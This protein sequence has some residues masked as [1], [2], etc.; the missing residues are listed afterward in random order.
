VGLN[1]WLVLTCWPWL[2][3]PRPSG[4]SALAAGLALVALTFGAVS[5]RRR[6][7]TATLAWL[8]AF[9]VLLG[10]SLAALPSENRQLSLGAWPLLLG[11]LGL[12]AHGASCLWALRRN[13]PVTPLRHQPLP[14][15]PLDAREGPAVPGSR[16]LA[17]ALLGGGALAIG[18]LAPLWGDAQPYAARWG[19]A[20]QE[21]ALLSAVVAAALGAAT[22]GPFLA[23]VLRP[24]RATAAPRPD[25]ALRV[26]S[27]VLLALLGAATYHVTR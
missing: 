27:L 6:P 9:P 24:A 10:A 17:A 21:G 20:A 1:P 8:L 26:A 23:A 16:A 18:V 11:V 13:Q 15:A 2:F 19:D 25:L 5:L 3:A 22:A 12:W 7:E 14:S 4:L